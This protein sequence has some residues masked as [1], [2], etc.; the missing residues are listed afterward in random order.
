MKNFPKMV[1]NTSEDT[2][3]LCQFILKERPNDVSDFSNLS[4][5]FMSGRKVGKI[6]TGSSDV[7]NTDRVGDFNYDDA[8]LYLVVETGGNAEWR[9][10]GLAS[11]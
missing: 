4:N 9:R 2:V 11:W 5:I 8:Y 1:V 3:T 10:V 6:P 7:E